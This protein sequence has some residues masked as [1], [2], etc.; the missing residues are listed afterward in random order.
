[1]IPPRLAAN[2]ASVVRQG[3]RWVLAIILLSTVCYVAAALYLGWREVLQG[4]RAVGVVGA[5]AA[6]ALTFV[7]LGL[8][9][10]RWRLYFKI[11][12]RPVSWLLN[13]RIYIAGF[14]LTGTPGKA[15][16]MIRS[17]L[18]KHH[19][20]P[21]SE[22]LAAFFSDRFTDLLAVVLLAFAGAW[23]YPALRPG[24]ILVT[25]VL[26]A[27][28]F[29]LSHP[30]LVQL[31]ESRAAK[32]AS[33]AGWRRRIAHLT[34]IITHCHRLFQPRVLLSA[35]ALALLAWGVEG[36]ILYA[37][38]HLVA[39]GLSLTVS[40]SIYA[41]SKLIG[42]AS[43]VPGGVG[44]V[45]L[46][47][48]GLLLAAGL[49]ETEALVCTVFVRVTTFWTAVILGTLTLTRHTYADLR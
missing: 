19:G 37:A 30:Q 4:L 21:Y 11:L 9:F 12:Q 7:N 20:V 3:S 16:E 1:M 42:A 28:V 25:L 23:T 39:G 31:I 17:L 10:L 45:E 49:G 44:V 27:I 8:R 15:G 40:L 36:V 38:T 13:L 5:L 29:L 43:L 18:L 41:L 24:A 2:P 35:I 46:S 32:H 47:M 22:S 48:A 33:D 26:A 34:W 14:A 6:V